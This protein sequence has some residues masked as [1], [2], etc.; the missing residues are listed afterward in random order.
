MG[1]VY[2]TGT[3]A[4]AVTTAI[5]MWEILAATGKPIR[6]HEWG[7]WQT[8]DVGDAAEEVLTIQEVRGVGTV[9]SGTGGST[10][11]VY[12]T[13]DGDAASGATVEANNTTRMAVGTGALD[14]LAPRGWN[15]RIPYEKIYTPECRPRINPGDRWTLAITTAPADSITIGTYIKYEEI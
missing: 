3:T 7:V 11:T 9:T 15:I 1:R 8:T 14:S 6:V 13:D 2:E 5:D 12:P 10:P 4:V